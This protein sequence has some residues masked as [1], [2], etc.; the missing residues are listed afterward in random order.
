MARTSTVDDEQFLQPRQCM[1]NVVHYSFGEVFLSWLALVLSKRKD[2]DRRTPFVSRQRLA[3]RPGGVSAD[4]QTIGTNGT[5]HV[6][7]R[8]VAEIGELNAL[9]AP[10]LLAD[11][12]R[13]HDAAG[14]GVGLQPGRDVDA[15]A[16]DILGFDDDVGDVDAH[17]EINLSGDRLIHIADDHLPLDLDRAVSGIVRVLEGGEEAIAGIL[18]DTSTILGDVRV[19][20]LRT[21]LPHPHVGDIFFGLHEPRVT[22]DISS[23]NR[24]QPT[25]RLFRRYRCARKPS[26]KQAHGWPPLSTHHGG[27]DPGKSQASCSRWHELEWV[28]FHNCRGI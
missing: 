14:L 20:Y 19:D 10:D 8:Q 28:Q 7:Q 16:V 15:V 27:V 26:P 13:Y 6:V 5:R 21:Q 17:P 3:H 24:E 12:V 4:K 23:Q 18:D 25:R 9:L 11:Q 22:H 1:D 2:D